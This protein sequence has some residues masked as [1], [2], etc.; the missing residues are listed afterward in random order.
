MDKPNDILAELT[1]LKADAVASQALLA[2]AQAAKTAFDAQ[3]A[4][5]A[6]ELADKDSSIAS[7]VS[8]AA[9]KDAELATLAA[10]IAGLKA[11]SKTANEQAIEIA[12]SAGV[13]P[14]KVDASAQAD[15]A[16][17]KD[18]I[19]AEL[20]AITDP[21]ARANYYFANKAALFGK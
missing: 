8:A 6:Q 3:V 21:V 13:A 12:A 14:L 20:S 4:L 2:E 18:E 1:A 7:L 16:K 10:E 11:T 15:A 5:T 19:I 17:S 9:V